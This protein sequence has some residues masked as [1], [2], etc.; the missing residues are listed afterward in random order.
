[1]DIQK[2]SLMQL[3]VDRGYA[4]PVCYADNG[5]SGLSLRRP[6]FMQMMTDMETGQVQAVIVRDI[7]R[8]GRNSVEV[9]QWIEDCHRA[10]VEII[11][12]CNGVLQPP[13]TRFY[14]AFA[15]LAK[16]GRLP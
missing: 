7:S 10:G 4:N 1:M 12:L 3:A 15:A 6:G 5:V 11:T 8:I 14:Q 13:V 16:G 2:N 9:L